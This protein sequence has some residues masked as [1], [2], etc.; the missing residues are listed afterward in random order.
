MN[1]KS[2]KELEWRMRW[3]F[4]ILVAGVPGIGLLKMT[5]QDQI[6]L[7]TCPASSRSHG[8]VSMFN[9][10]LLKSSPELHYGER[11]KTFRCRVQRTS[12]GRSKPVLN[13]THTHTRNNKKKSANTFTLPLLFSSNEISVSCIRFT[14]TPLMSFCD[15]NPTEF[16]QCVAYVR[17]YKIKIQIW[18]FKVKIFC[19]LVTLKTRLELQERDF[20]NKSVFNFYFKCCFSPPMYVCVCDRERARERELWE[21]F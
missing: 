19:H 18:P 3:D 20:S 9:S 7:F 8:R 16:T 13:F 4:S 12:K 14:M 5:E 6:E 11:K 1:D 2:V 17:P 10:K 15:F 21:M